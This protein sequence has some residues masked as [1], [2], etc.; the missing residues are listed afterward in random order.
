MD[1][2]GQELALA[3]ARTRLTLART[4]MHASKV[5]LVD[6]VLAA[7]LK[8]VDDID[9]AD[10]RSVAELSFRRTGLAASLVAILLLVVGL[11]GYQ[12]ARSM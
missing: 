3:E 10:Q 8:L 1:V 12:I 9:A 5:E 7:G 11:A 6:P 2:N 4:E